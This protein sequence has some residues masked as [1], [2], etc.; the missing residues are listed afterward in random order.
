MP[1]YGADIRLGRARARNA[2]FG[3]GRLGAS[4]PRSSVP[5][6]RP[7]VRLRRGRRDHRSRRPD[8][9]RGARGFAPSDRVAYWRVALDDIEPIHSLGSG[10]GSFEVAWLHYRT[11]PVSTLDAHNL[12]LETLAELGPLGLALLLG[13]LFVPLRCLLSRPRR[14]VTVAAGGA[15]VAFLVH[16][17]L[18]WDW[19][20][21]AVVVTGLVCGLALT[22]ASHDDAMPRRVVRGRST[23]LAAA[24]TLACVAPVTAE[25]IGIRR[26]PQLS[27]PRRPATGRPSK[28]VRGSLRAGNP[29][30]HSRSSFLGS[31]RLPRATSRWLG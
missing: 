25:L 22:V 30:R 31:A 13:A 28:A 27:T 7:G 14:P 4:A 6:R 8:R 17:A 26:S 2:R 3:L 12:Y 11:S 9:R 24:L 15:Y 10:A 1:L 18:D 23:A 19:E 16:A 29:G 5:Y 21:P 20:M